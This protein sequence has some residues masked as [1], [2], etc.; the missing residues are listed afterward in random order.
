MIVWDKQTPGL[1]FGWRMQHELCIFGLKTKPEWDNH[2][3]YGN[4]IQMQRSGNELHPTQKPVAL[5][6]K[7][8]DNTAWASGVLDFFGGSGTTLI[9]AEHQGQ[10]SWIMELTE[11]YTDVIVRRYAKET[12]DIG[13][14]SLLRGGREVSR[15]EWDDILDGIE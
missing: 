3:G 11:G 15:A 13:G 1:G 8:L 14:I 7:L 2:K 9:A 12:G 6:E 10:Q 4:V 5:I